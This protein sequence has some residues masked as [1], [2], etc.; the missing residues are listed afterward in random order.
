MKRVLILPLPSSNS[1]QVPCGAGEEI[2]I[3]TLN[4]ACTG[5][6]QGEQAWIAIFRSSGVLALSVSPPMPTSITFLT[7]FINAPAASQT[8]VD[9][10]VVATGVNVFNTVPLQQELALPDIWWPWAVNVQLSMSTVT[11][12]SAVLVYEVREVRKAS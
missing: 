2:Q 8:L 12:T 5:G 9:S 1:V 7:A 11:P 10:Q 4:A 6:T 3:I